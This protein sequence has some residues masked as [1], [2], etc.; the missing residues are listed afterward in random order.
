MNI[1]NPFEHL[2]EPC[3]H[4][5]SRG[6]QDMCNLLGSENLHYFPLNT[7]KNFVAT[8]EIF[9]QEYDEC[10]T[11]TLPSYFKRAFKDN[12]KEMSNN[13][14]S[15]CS[16]NEGSIF[17]QDK[18]DNI[19]DFLDNEGLFIISPT[20]S[21]PSFGLK[22]CVNIASLSRLQS[23]EEKEEKMLNDELEDLALPTFLIRRSSSRS[24]KSKG[25]TL[26]SDKENTK[27]RFCTILNEKEQAFQESRV[28]E[29]PIKERL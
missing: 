18:Y 4:N 10:I 25:L 27:S 26:G 8:G 6:L 13:S 29:S 22:P 28:Q 24:D 17:D 23:F 12:F 15:P 5:L 2:P 21:K 7:Q 16:Q 20:L 19:E 1:S 14:Y 3:E 11:P 9:E